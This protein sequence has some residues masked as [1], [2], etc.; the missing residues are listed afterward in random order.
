M[1][2]RRIIF[3]KIAVNANIGVLEHE[4]IATQPIHIDAD[5]EID[6]TRTLDDTDINSVLDYRTLHDTIVSECTSGHINLLETLTDRV[7]QSLLRTFP[8]TRTVTVRITKP[9]AF[10]DSDGVAIEVCRQRAL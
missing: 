7:A 5:I 8:E 10:A 3:S 2:T 1:P 4:Q 9:L 6:V